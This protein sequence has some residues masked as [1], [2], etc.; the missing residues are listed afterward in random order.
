LVSNLIDLENKTPS[1]NKRGG[2]LLL[3]D[4]LIPLPI[5]ILNNTLNNKNNLDMALFGKQARERRKKRRAKRKEKIKNVIKK[6][7]TKTD[8]ARRKVA[9]LKVAP[10]AP[11]MR[12]ML[13]KRG[14]KAPTG[15]RN[16]DKLTA[17][18]YLNVVKKMPNNYEFSEGI[19]EEYQIVNPE[20][21]FHGLNNQGGNSIEFSFNQYEVNNIEDVSPED[22]AKVVEDTNA[23]ISVIDKIVGLINRITTKIKGGQT[24]DETEKEIAK[25]TEESKDEIDSETEGIFGGSNVLLIIGI[26]VVAF[27]V[28]KK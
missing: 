3:A 6:V 2:F 24:L 12:K 28:F 27:F 22:V 11:V 20:N 13:K 1:L 9:L 25:T 4:L 8:K 15:I 19:S 21:P 16:L 5:T 23:F 18:F 26:I 10:F 7:T 14:F 17:S